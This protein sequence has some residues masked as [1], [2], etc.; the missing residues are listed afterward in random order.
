MKWHTHMPGE[1]LSPAE[2]DEQQPPAE[3][4]ES[5]R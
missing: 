3:G 2:D 5:N 1:P 4:D